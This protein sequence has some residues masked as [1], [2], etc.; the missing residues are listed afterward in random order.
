MVFGDEGNEI[1]YIKI[2]TK[3]RVYD[4]INMYLRVYLRNKYILSDI[5]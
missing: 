1:V 3:I 4:R 2:L 5:E